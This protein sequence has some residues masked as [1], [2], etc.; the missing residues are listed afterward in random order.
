V[1][2]EQDVHADHDGHHGEHVKRDGY[3]SS[4][5]LVLL[6]AQAWSKRTSGHEKRLSRAGCG[7]QTSSMSDGV[8]RWPN[9]PVTPGLAN[10]GMKPFPVAV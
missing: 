4:H 10:S 2:E 7:R 3:L 9:R 1:P 5:C 6:C 8:V